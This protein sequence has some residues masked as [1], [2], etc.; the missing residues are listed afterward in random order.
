MYQINCEMNGRSGTLNIPY[1]FYRVGGS[2][3]CIYEGMQIATTGRLGPSTTQKTLPVSI[4]GSSDVI[5]VMVEI[6]PQENMADAYWIL[7]L[8]CF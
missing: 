3:S 6:V 2:I 7:R 4:N 1:Y 5:K 8:D